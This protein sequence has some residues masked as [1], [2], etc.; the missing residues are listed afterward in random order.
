MDDNFLNF[1]SLLEKR[2]VEERTVSQ[3][4][5]KLVQGR[6]RRGLTIQQRKRLQSFDR[7]STTE[8]MGL[9][10]IEESKLEP[11]DLKSAR[12]SQPPFVN[13]PSFRANIVILRFLGFFHEIKALLFLLNRRTGQYYESHRELIEVYI[14]SER[15]ISTAINFGE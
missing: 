11:Q 5:L 12:P 4:H 9:Q 6:V 13:L 15:I 8:K 3:K 7:K 10:S 2:Q 1:D 14:R